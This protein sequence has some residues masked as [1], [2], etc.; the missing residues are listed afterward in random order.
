MLNPDDFKQAIQTIDAL[1]ATPAA[2]AKVMELAKEPDV[3]LEA[4]CKLLRNDGPLTANI[5]RISN[6]PYYAP[7]TVHS[8]LASAINYIGMREVIRVVSLSLAQELFARDLPSY[9]ISASE[10]WSDSIAAALVM[11]ALADDAGL[12]GEDAYTLGILHAIGRV[13]INRVI[14]EKRF[15]IYW[16]GQQPIENWERSFV[17]FDYAEAGALLLEH[18]QFP[19]AMCDII[20]GQL[21]PEKAGEPVSW[22]GRLR[23]TR[24]LLALTGTNFENQNWQLP[25]TD[26]FVQAS[27][28]TPEWVADLVATCRADYQRIMQSADLG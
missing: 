12:N 13:L 11:E 20:R 22:S 4:V 7:A 23:F 3:D 6:S 16:D 25:P 8:N 5:I 2:L 1:G 15:S 18:W 27:R 24:R 26:A 17:G 9:G 21:E 28:L 19:Q 14:E 10:Y